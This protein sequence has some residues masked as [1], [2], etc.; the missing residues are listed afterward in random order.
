MKPK[1]FYQRVEEQVRKNIHPD[2]ADFQTKQEFGLLKFFYVPDKSIHYEVWIQR[3]SGL[4]EIG[5][6]FEGER[7]KNQKYI[8]FMSEHALEIQ[9]EFG[10]RLDF[11]YWTTNWT[12]VHQMRPMSALDESFANEVVDKVVRL[13]EACEPLI[14]NFQKKIAS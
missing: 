10:G 12:R 8:D 13:M 6:H 5:L 7:E 4:L 11:E 9:A 3:R 1:D 2:L 14:R